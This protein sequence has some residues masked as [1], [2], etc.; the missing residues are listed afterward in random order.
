[1]PNEQKERKNEAKSGR[2]D[3]TQFSCFSL[4][5]F[6]RAH[7]RFAHPQESHPGYDALDEAFVTTM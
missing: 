7:D 4:K 1:M 2:A 6:A 3:A 5:A